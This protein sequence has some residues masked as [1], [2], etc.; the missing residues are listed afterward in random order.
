MDSD[1]VNGTPL[2]RKDNPRTLTG[3]A[4]ETKIRQQNP[5]RA[6]GIAVATNITRVSCIAALACWLKDVLKDS[7]RR[8]GERLFMSADEEAH[9]RGWQIAQ[10]WGGL[11][12]IYRDPRFDTLHARSD[13]ADGDSPAPL[14]QL[15]PQVPP[16]GAR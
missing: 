1:L 13:Q 4:T 11:S 10:L 3:N 8:A 16:D 14:G 5:S 12:R 9:W 7:S 15:S 6:T 2:V